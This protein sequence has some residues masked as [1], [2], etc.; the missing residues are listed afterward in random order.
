MRV[1]GDIILNASFFD[2]VSR[3]PEWPAGQEAKWS[4]GAHL[5]PSPTTTT[6]S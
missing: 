2:S 5:G 1:A 6:S 3:N 4:Q